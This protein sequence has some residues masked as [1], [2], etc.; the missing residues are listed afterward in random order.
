MHSPLIILWSTNLPACA[1]HQNRRQPKE[2]R[3]RLFII[4]S[5]FFCAVCTTPGTSAALPNKTQAA[6]SAEPGLADLVRQIFADEQ[7]S[8]EYLVYISENWESLDNLVSQVRADGFL[9]QESRKAVARLLGGEY[10]K[11]A[12]KTPLAVTDRRIL[13]R[14]VRETVRFWGRNA[15][16]HADNLLRVKCALLAS[17]K[18]V[19]ND[20]VIKELLEKNSRRLEKT[21]RVA[22]D[23][24][25]YLAE[26]L[27]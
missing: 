8:A 3:M 16:L 1:G 17:A 27:K 4:V 10:G 21:Y 12:A 18:L 25:D 22:K 11:I 24:A 26:D 14:A 23:L 2:E 19:G 20:A 15:L 7:K 13:L 9:T 6:P 5:M